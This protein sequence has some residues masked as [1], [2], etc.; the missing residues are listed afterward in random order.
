MLTR[1]FYPRPAEPGKFTSVNPRKLLP[2]RE[3]PAPLLLYPPIL[4]SEAQQ[5]CNRP[6]PISTEYALSTHIVPAAYPRVTPFV[7]L[8]ASF[9][10]LHSSTSRLNKEERKS[11][12]K[13]ITEEI[14]CFKQR[15]AAGEFPP[16]EREDRVLW[17]CVSRYYRRS[18]LELAGEQERKKRITLFL[19]H[20]NGFP[21]ETWEPFIRHLVSIIEHSD[22]SSVLVDEIWSFE[23][24]QHGDAALINEDKL[25]AL[26]DWS[27]YS[28]DILNFLTR[29]LPSR[30]QSF[31]SE[32]P[33]HLPRVS[34]RV[35]RIRLERGFED[36]RTL[37]CVGHSM[38]GSAVALAAL[39]IPSIFT[40]LTLVDPVIIPPYADRGSNIYA[41][42]LGAIARRHEWPSREEAR[43][44][45]AA[46]PF[47]AVWEPAV[48]NAYVECGLTPISPSS[49]SSQGVRLKMSGV[50]EANVFAESRVSFEIFERLKDLDPRIALHW[51]MA[52]KES[53]ITGSEAATRDLV[54]RRPANATNSQIVD[55]AHLIAQQA[56]EEL[57]L[58]V[59]A[60]LERLFG[61]VNAKARL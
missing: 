9:A 55:S 38:G 20:A 3:P 37:V 36:E 34:D 29:Y 49:S 52:G 19:T 54:W 57:A 31:N 2:L 28:R 11:L 26:Y 58:E 60:F 21:K 25:G 30:S 59:H 17:N 46:S 33:V 42:C 41:L 12:S 22:N 35:E 1:N 5:R 16:D 39:T 10:S 47:F 7:P 24:V 27:D 56:P 18:L 14:I 13:K 32:L 53:W 43:K 44:L 61:G 6:S 51:V 4:P 23:A 40:A 50:Q 15:Q 45:L 48:L 8:P